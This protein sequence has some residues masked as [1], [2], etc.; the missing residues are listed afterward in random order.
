MHEDTRI[1]PLSPTELGRLGVNQIAYIKSV[2]VDSEQKFAVHS[3]DGT[4]VTVFPSYEL[5]RLA[6]RQSDLVPLSVH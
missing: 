6:I 5:A 4:V 2:E 1:P 3:A